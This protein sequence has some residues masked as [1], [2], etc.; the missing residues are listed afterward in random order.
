M[1]SLLKLAP[2]FCALAFMSAAAHGVVLLDTGPN[3][4][5]NAYRYQAA[6]A[7][8]QGALANATASTFQ[9]SQSGPVL[10]GNLISINSA[11]EGR[12]TT[13]SLGELGGNYWIGLNDTANES[14]GPVSAARNRGIVATGTLGWVHSDG[15]PHTYTNWNGGEPNDAGGEDAIESLVNGLWNDLPDN[16]GGVLRAAVYEYQTQLNHP[17]QIDGFQ[18]RMAKAYNNIQ[19]M[20]IAESVVAGQIASVQTSQAVANMNFQENG[21][22]GLHF[23]GGLQVPGIAGD[24]SNFVSRTTGNLNV[25]AAG[26]YTFGFTS[27]DGGK[28]VVDGVTVAE[29]FGNRGNSDSIGAPIFLSAGNHTV[30]FMWYEQGGGAS[31]EAFYTS[32]VAGDFGSGT[33]V[34]IGDGSQGIS[35]NNLMTTTYHVQIPNTGDV[36]NLA[37]AEALFNGGTAATQ[38]TY[39]T[40]V[41]N[42]RDTGGE[43]LFGG[44]DP[45]LFLEGTDGDDFAILATTQIDV[46][47]AGLYQFGANTDDGSRIRING[48]DYLIDDVLAG[49]HTVLGPQIFL[50]VGLH[51]LE[52]LFF[53]RGGGAEAELF[54]VLPSGQQ[55]LLGDTANGALRVTLQSLAPVVPEPATALMGLLALGSLARRRRREA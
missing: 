44:N 22:D 32:G 55:V 1:N 3:G 51:D 40:N 12:L 46:Q 50:P 9:A 41:V 27:D 25:G 48:A 21:N 52:F 18:I 28:L 20:V 39:F 29:F 4:S 8:W 2:A 43:G 6:G 38:Y 16:N 7:T 11:Q 31:G 47:V 23:G 45:F 19:N 35:A 24:Q 54:Q 36:N 30:E 49:P 53:E 10:N 42:M 34:L 26:L 37:A 5:I 14:G 15:S 33:F 13:R 17:S